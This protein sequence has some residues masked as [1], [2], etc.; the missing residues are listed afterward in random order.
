MEENNMELNKSFDTIRKRVDNLSKEIAVKRG[1]RKEGGGNDF[2]HNNNLA[3]QY[4]KNNNENKENEKGQY[5]NN[6]RVQSNESE[7]D[8]NKQQN[9]I[10]GKIIQLEKDLD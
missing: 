2:N 8:Y 1:K 10:L 4:N 6:Q 3:R 7:R 5:G 9:Y